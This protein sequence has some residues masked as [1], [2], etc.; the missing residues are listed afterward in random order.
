[1]S[2][3]KLQPYLQIACLVSTFT[4]HHSLDT[5]CCLSR[6]LPSPFSLTGGMLAGGGEGP[7][8]QI[9]GAFYPL[10]RHTLARR[11]PVVF[12]IKSGSAVP[13]LSLSLSLSNFRQ[14]R[15]SAASRSRARARG[16]L[17]R[18]VLHP[19][20]SSAEEDHQDPDQFTG[21]PQSVRLRPR[22]AFALNHVHP[23]QRA[24]GNK[25]Q[26]MSTLPSLEC[27][28][29]ATTSSCCPRC[30]WKSSRIIAAGLRIPPSLSDWP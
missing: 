14:S 8:V 30:V 11:C 6:G 23:R 27:V 15:F 7:G 28:T 9:T 25:R 26:A 1:M 20:V 4:R 5:H 3:L 12:V 2:V 24:W 18:L 19:E 17:A 16:E 22:L 13:S 29:A 10:K 21:V